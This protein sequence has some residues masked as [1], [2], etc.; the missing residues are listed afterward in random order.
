ME[1]LR[2]CDSSELPE[3]PHARWNT[4]GSFTVVANYDIYRSC[5]MDTKDSHGK[6]NMNAVQ[7]IGDSESGAATAMQKTLTG[8]AYVSHDPVP[9]NPYFKG[10][11]DHLPLAYGTKSTRKTM[12]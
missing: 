12:I 3:H 5:G 8:V 4:V 10:A 2:I 9:G 7:D 6:M 1:D 11:Q